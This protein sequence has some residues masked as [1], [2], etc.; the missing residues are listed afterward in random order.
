MVAGVDTGIDI[1]EIVLSNSTF[2]PQEIRRISAAIG[3]DFSKHSTLRES[4][5]ELNSR[6][7]QT[8]AS[9][10]RLGV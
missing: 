10:V 2:G 8:P 4:V 6:G 3:E 7:E 1:K 9:A 5:A